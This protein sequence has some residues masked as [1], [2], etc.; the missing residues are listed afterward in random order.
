MAEVPES[1][2]DPQAIPQ[3][4][5]GPHGQPVLLS[6]QLHRDGHGVVCPAGNSSDSRWPSILVT[7]CPCLPGPSPDHLGYVPPLATSWQGKT[8][9]ERLRPSRATEHGA[10]CLHLQTTGSPVLSE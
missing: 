9:L 8:G 1:P 4:K 2:G 7:F 6:Q 3:I 10:C 5:R